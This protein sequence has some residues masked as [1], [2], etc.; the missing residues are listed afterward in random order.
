MT[1]GTERRAHARHICNTGVLAD[2]ADDRHASGPS[3]GTVPQGDACPLIR[4]H[5]PARRNLPHGVH[6]TSACASH[7]PLRP[8]RAP[9]VLTGTALIALA[10]SDP[11]RAQSTAATVTRNAAQ[12]THTYDIPAQ[13][14][15]SALLGFGKQSG[16]AVT[17]PG[18]LLRGKTTAGLH[19]Q[20]TSSDA[21]ARLL[22]GSGLSYQ[23]VGEKAF[24]IIPAPGAASITLGPVR[25]GGTVAATPASDPQAPYGP[26]EGFF[27]ARSTAGTKTDT[28]IVKTPQSIYVINRQQM[29]DLQ[30]LTIDEA[31]RYAPGISDPVD[32]GGTPWAN[33]H[34]IYQRGFQSDTFVD[35]LMTGVDPSIAEPFMMDRIEAL[36]GPASVMYGS[37]APG[38]I[39]NVGL[40]RPTEKAQHQVNIG[41]GSYGRYQGQFDSSG[42]MTKQGNLLYRIVA[43]GDT[44][45]DQVR[46]NKYKRL[47]VQ[48]AITWKI[49]SKTELT[50][51]GQYNY[52]PMMNQ[53]S[54]A[55]ALGS[56]F[57][58]QYVRYS[59][60]L[61]AGDPGFDTSRDTSYMFEYIFSHKFNKH[62]QFSQNFRYEHDDWYFTDLFSDGLVN[63]TSEMERYAM[64]Y[65]NHGYSVL[66][67]THLQG[68][69]STG[70]VKHT[71]LVG[72]DYRLQRAWGKWMFD[73]S[74]PSLNLLAPV[75]YQYNM[76][77]LM[78]ASGGKWGSEDDYLNQNGIYFQEQLQWK[79]L[80][81]MLAG[82]EDWDNWYN[83]FQRAFT[84]H[85]GASYQF[86][87]GLAPYFSYA[88][89]FNPQS[90]NIYGA[91][92]AA[93]LVG[94]QWEVGLKYQPPGSKMLFTAA[95]YDLRED[96]VLVND[97]YHQN[98]SLQ[99]GQVRVRGVDLS[100]NVN[101]AEGLNLSA[102]YSYM[103]PENSRSNLTSKNLA[104]NLVSTQG[105][106]PTELPRNTVSLLVD[107]KFPRGILQGL[108][109]NA[110]MRYV[111][112]TQGDMANSFHVPGYTVFDGG[113]DYD[114]GKLSS[115]LKGVNFRV[116][117]VNAF[118]KEYVVECTSGT[119]C[120]W[121]QLR[122]VFGTIGYRW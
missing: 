10:L 54:A 43:M 22:Q 53:S 88:T 47:I 18:E 46:Y 41:F 109:F 3:Q 21:L 73:F 82:R 80:N 115:T 23:P 40:K 33:T 50:L 78:A 106:S 87:F 61:N 119:S 9:F 56:I 74:A 16:L 62:L 36:S 94:K 5:Q 20:F 116:S 91:G 42:P 98:F 60:S 4:F 34:D 35:G 96:N 76:K 24:Q 1:S 68:D 99:I 15:V 79:G 112:F 44:Q 95:A 6:D 110:G 104:G 30:P 38:G 108:S 7:R 2:G 117:L 70:P 100:A 103:Y 120:G 107:Y 69:F 52:T 75:Y 85:A 48:P 31:L 11:A 45:D 67:D 72:V 114:F 121:G 89:S 102:T 65:A 25:V 118:N 86:G 17:A 71:V 37:A 12:A 51:I 83:K 27:V 63:G 97:P 92:Q 29:D 14:L 93:P 111:G 19:G 49:D 8:S 81:V 101:I 113:A 39:I 66:L 57:P 13:S 58:K 59:P 105:K 77:N 64:A 28:P 55:P 122:R 32:G 90:G 84:W 26:G